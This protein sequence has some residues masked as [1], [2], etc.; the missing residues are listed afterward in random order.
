[1]KGGIEMSI[2]ASITFLICCGITSWQLDIKKI[3]K[4]PAWFY[5]MGCLAG[6]V[7]V[8]IILIGRN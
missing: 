6:Q 4:H 2:M 5:L 3:V 8:L 7:S 1:M